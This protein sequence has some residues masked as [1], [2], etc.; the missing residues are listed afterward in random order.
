MSDTIF[1]DISLFIRHH[2]RLSFFHLK[3]N[4]EFNE[5]HIP[6]NLVAIECLLFMWNKCDMNVARNEK[7]IGRVIDILFSVIPNKIK[8]HEKNQIS[9][10]VGVLFF[11]I[12]YLFMNTNP[13]R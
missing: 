6:F 4:F 3:A 11:L 13:P 1:D 10:L 8:T 5:V 12:L 7:R 9:L 2:R